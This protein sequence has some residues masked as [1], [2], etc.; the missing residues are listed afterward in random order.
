VARGL[1]FQTA[2]EIEKVQYAQENSVMILCE[3]NHRPLEIGYKTYSTEPEAEPHFWKAFY[4]KWANISIA[5]ETKVSGEITD[6]VYEQEDDSGYKNNGWLN[7]NGE[8]PRCVTFFNGRLVYAGTVSS[9]QRIFISGIKDKQNFATYKKLLAE[10]REYAAVRG[11]L[12]ENELDVITAD[13]TEEILNL[14]KKY[15]DYYIDS[16][17]FEKGT[18]I[19]TVNDR[20]ITLTGARKSLGISAEM[21]AGCTEWKNAIYATDEVPQLS[22]VPSGSNRGVYPGE[23]FYLIYYRADT[24]DST[25]WDDNYYWVYLFFG[26][27]VSTGK[28]WYFFFTKHNYGNVFG[29]TYGPMTL[30]AQAEI[31]IEQTAAR[32]CVNSQQALF[33]YVKEKFALGSAYTGWNY[34]LFI[35]D[36]FAYIGKK[37]TNA[38]NKM[39]YVIVGAEDNITAEFYGTPIQIEQEIQTYDVVSSSQAASAIFSFYTRTIESSTIGTAEDGFTF[40]IASDMGDAIRWI[41]QNKHLIAGTDT[42]E[43]VIPGSTTAVN[44]Q[45][46]LNSRYGSDV[47]P[48]QT[49]GD[50]V[51]FAQSGKK[52]L[53]EYYIPQ[54]DTNFRANNLAVLS[55][56]MLG[57]SPAAG[58]DFVSTPYTKL[59]IP[60]KRGDLAV[61]LYDRGL[62]VFAWSRVSTRGAIKSLAVV[63][64]DDG[65]D[66]VYCLIER[67]ETLFM[68][69]LDCGGD[70]YL[71]GYAALEEGEEI[72]EGMETVEKE[73]T[74]GTVRRY[75]GY[76]YAS[77]VRSLP[78]LANNQMKKQRITTIIF[79]FLESFFPDVAALA[80]G[81]KIKTD[82]ITGREA[83]YSGVFKIPFPG[84]W[85]ED[86][87]FELSFD[88]PLPVK[89]LVMNAE[90]Q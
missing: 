65:L 36:L 74:G 23:N 29:S 89:I 34:P 85:D 14:A 45:A 63:P 69:K 51:L 86:V 80:G 55:K 27:G 35:S 39:A 3:E 38:D 19:F 11:K 77:I 10:R 72:P 58:I 1:F 41:T 62:G 57:E 88:R 18:K 46:I 44:I 33:D 53:V 6:L 13:T 15:Q 21:K 22:Y 60:R 82:V 20:D 26:K 9:P 66:E 31:T 32:E 48:G 47:I 56:N 8:Y 42:A 37:N 87:Q 5:V 79:R 68:E 61:L 81:K 43:W 78:I 2:A 25:V 12:G 54:Q 7:K 64:G 24:E 76:P 73:D 50:A 70:V 83:P 40:E 16:P 71:D 30:A 17:Y 90:A 49:I 67:G 59:F 4:C 28:I 84:T 52:S 75:A